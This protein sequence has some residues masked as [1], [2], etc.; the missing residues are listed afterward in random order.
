MIGARVIKILGYDDWERAICQ[1]CIEPGRC[2]TRFN[3]SNEAGEPRTCW[4]DERPTPSDG[5]PF[6]PIERWGQWTVEGGPDV[7]RTYSAWLWRC[8]A[9]DTATGRCGI[10]DTRPELCK[11]YEPLEDHL[12]VMKP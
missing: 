8:T 5:H 10:Y 3:L 9:L 4:D 11:R 2:C 1:R 6:E 12:C 7:G